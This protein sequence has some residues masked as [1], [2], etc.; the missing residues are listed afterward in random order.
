MSLRQKAPTEHAINRE[1]LFLLKLK[2]IAWR[3]VM[4]GE[5]TLLY[6]SVG[7]MNQLFVLY[8]VHCNMF[9]LFKR[10]KFYINLDLL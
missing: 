5:E 7:G 1:M 2:F 4:F 6:Y 10:S 3:R 9:V 8:S